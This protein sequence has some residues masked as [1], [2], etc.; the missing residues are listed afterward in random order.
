MFHVI[1][2]TSCLCYEYLPLVIHEEAFFSLIL[3]TFFDTLLQVGSFNY[4]MSKMVFSNE[5]V[6][7]KEDAIKSILDYEIEINDL[8]PH[9]THYMALGMNY[10]VAGFEMILTRKISFYVVTYYLPSGKSDYSLLILEL[11]R[12][13]FQGILVILIQASSSLCLGYLSWSIRKSYRAA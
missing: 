7:T 5:F 2:S 13:Q 9:Q 4:D 1:L 10:S 6:P 3:V 11:L 8:R 12:L